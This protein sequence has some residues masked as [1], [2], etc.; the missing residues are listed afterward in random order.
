[1]LQRSGETWSAVESLT[2]SQIS[3]VA[4]SQDGRTALLGGEGSAQFYTNVCTGLQVATSNLPVA[5]RGVPYEAKVAACG[6]SPRYKWKQ[7]GKLPKGLKLTS[8]G[9]I[10]GTPSARLV[11]NTYP[12]AV[13]VTDSEKPKQSASTTLTLEVQ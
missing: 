12:I 8:V 7:E 13:K 10:D 3:G 1:V 11:A 5:R 6:G 4:L 2:F 9:I